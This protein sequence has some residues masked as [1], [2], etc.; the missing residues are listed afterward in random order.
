MSE[1][2]IET[3]LPNHAPYDLIKEGKISVPF[4]K[5]YKDYF[6]QYELLFKAIRL[7]HFNVVKFLIDVG[8][9]IES[10]NEHEDTLLMWATTFGH[11]NI[12]ALLIEKGANI[13]EGVWTPLMLASINSRLKIV[14]FLIDKGAD[15]EVKD[16]YE[17][18]T[19]LKLAITHNRFDIVKILVENK[20]DIEDE[21]VTFAYRINNLN[22]ADY[23]QEK[24]DERRRNRSKSSQLYIR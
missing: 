18:R 22:I 2:E 6:D 19:A 1:E 11:Y 24:T 10:K 3:N 23:L 4:F 15:I 13:N 16:D 9:N 5:Q 14:Q 8:V 21:Y 20:A 17:G 7:G 12:I